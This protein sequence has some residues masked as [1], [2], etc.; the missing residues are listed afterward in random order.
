MRLHDKAWENEAIQYVDFMSLYPYVCKYFKFPVVHLG[1][2]V[3]D[4]CE[5]MEAYL[6]MD[7]LIKC[8][9]VPPE[10][11]YHPVLPFRCNKI[12]C[13]NFLYRIVQTCHG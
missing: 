4:A 1:I 9:I 5:K 7:D 2:H 3:G 11:V 8:S 6:R 12:S 10:K 13:R